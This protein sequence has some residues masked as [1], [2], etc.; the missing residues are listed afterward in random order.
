M[1][2]VCSSPS[3]GAIARQGSFG[4]LAGASD[5]D[6]SQGEVIEVGETITAEE[7]L[8]ARFLAAESRGEVVEIL[9]DETEVEEEGGVDERG[10]SAEELSVRAEF[11]KEIASVSF[12]GEEES[13]EE[14]A[15]E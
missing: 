13:E 7:S 3:P 6:W 8:D 9:S 14:E 5:D 2:R 12:Q 15:E 11:R 4:G 10:A 1:C